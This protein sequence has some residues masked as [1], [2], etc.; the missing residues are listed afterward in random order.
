MNRKFLLSIG[1]VVISSSLFVTGCVGT[2]TREGGATEEKKRVTLTFPKDMKNNPDFNEGRDYISSNEYNEDE[3]SEYDYD[4]SL[5]IDESENDEYETYTSTGI[6]L[7]SLEECKVNRVVDGDTFVTTINGKEVK[8]RL[9]GVDTPESVASDEYLEQSGK[10]NTEAG[11]E[12]SEYTKSLISDTTVYLEFDASTEDK[13][14][15]LLAYV[16]LDNGEMLQDILL[17]NG[18]AN[19][20]TIQPNVKYS[21]HFVEVV[22]ASR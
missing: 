13:Y 2:P 10:E 21:D 11:V 22:E 8:V 4:S 9:I 16:Y 18:Y 7:S 6:A 12:A 14:G 17:S 1:I 15:R 19:L 3:E 5:Y 20:M